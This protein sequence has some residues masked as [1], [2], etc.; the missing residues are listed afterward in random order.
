MKQLA[1]WILGLIE[2][3]ILLMMK[4]IKVL[5]G[6]ISAD[7]AVGGGKVIKIPRDTLRIKGPDP[8]QPPSSEPARCLLSS[9]QKADVCLLTQ[10]A[11]VAPEISLRDS[12]IYSFWQ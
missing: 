6:N 12:R 8:P 4:F 2:C 10:R 3:P 1:I 7:S 5:G 9:S 11:L